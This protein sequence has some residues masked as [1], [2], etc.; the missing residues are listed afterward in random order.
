[1]KPAKEFPSRAQKG[2]TWLAKTHL[3]LSTTD[4]THNDESF[5]WWFEVGID[6]SM[7]D[8]HSIWD[9]RRWCEE[10]LLPR[11]PK[12]VQEFIATLLQAGWKPHPPGFADRFSQP[13]DA[14]EM[15]VPRCDL[16]CVPS[17]PLQV[18]YVQRVSKGVALGVTVQG[19]TSTT[20]HHGCFFLGGWGTF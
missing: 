18:D 1:M 12:E 10:Y 16:S 6:E 5:R 9:W 2:E 20:K 3:T 19:T 15:M 7:F 14:W 17:L 4:A 13:K 11:G 8:F